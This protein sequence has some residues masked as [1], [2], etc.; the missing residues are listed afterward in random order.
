MALG[1]CG[2]APAHPHPVRAY[3]PALPLNGDYDLTIHTP[4]IGPI[5]THITA[6]PTETGFKANTRPG[7]AW[8]MIGG[9]EGFIGPLFMPFLFPS[10][11]ILT[12]DSTLPSAEKPGEGT[13]GIGTLP[14]MRVRTRMTG[15]D[16]PIEAVL[17]DGRTVALLTL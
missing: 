6:A 15:P 11:M 5:Q 4:W 7:V 16:R 13:I 1:G 12:W 14:A 2:T 8:S 10:G 3:G 9:F 17:K